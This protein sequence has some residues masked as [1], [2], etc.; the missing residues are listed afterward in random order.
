MSNKLYITNLASDTTETELNQIFG[1]V[2]GILSLSISTDP[3]S[4]ARKSYGFVEMESPEVTQ[5]AIQRVSGYMLH[6]RRIMITELK[7]PS[8]RRHAEIDDSP[9]QENRP[10]KRSA[11]SK[12]AS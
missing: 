1:Q 12:R 6:D 2:G 8:E 3:R 4:G 10:K 11:K 9:S 7:P 5:A